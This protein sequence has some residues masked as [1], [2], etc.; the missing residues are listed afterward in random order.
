MEDSVLQQQAETDNPFDGAEDLLGFRRQIFA[1]C[2]VLFCPLCLVLR[3]VQSQ[4]GF[5]NGTEIKLIDLT[6]LMNILVSYIV[7]VLC[8]DNAT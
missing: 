4:V 6:L 7:P 2:P 8:H 5:W 3:V 1:A